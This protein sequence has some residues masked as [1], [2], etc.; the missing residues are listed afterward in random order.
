MP[1]CRGVRHSIKPGNKKKS[2]VLSHAGLFPGRSPGNAFGLPPAPW[3]ES[4][5]A[6]AR[7]KKNYFFFFLAAFLAVFFFAA[8]FLAAMSSLLCCH[9]VPPQTRQA[10]PRQLAVCQ[11]TTCWCRTSSPSLLRT[12][13]NGC[14]PCSRRMARRV[15]RTLPVRPRPIACRDRPLLVGSSPPNF[16]SI[17][18][19][20]RWGAQTLRAM[21]RPPTTVRPT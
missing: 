17:L 10:P 20:P 3:D 19:G 8:F 14:K 13:E 6:A 11:H 9:C 1:G 21:A 16:R 5:G 18:Y 2:R 15:W 12:V 7:P 4:R